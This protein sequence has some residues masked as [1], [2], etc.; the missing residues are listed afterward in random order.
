M[1]LDQ[2]IALQYQQRGFVVLDGLFDAE[3]VQLMNERT[4]TLFGQP[5]SARVLEKDGKTVRAVHGCHLHDDLFGAMVRDPRLIDPAQQ[6]LGGDVYVFQFKINAKAAFTGDVWEWHQ[7]Y[8][9]WREE[10]GVER[11]D[12]VNV[13]IFLD[14]VHE[15]NGPLTFIPGSH[16][17]GV[18]AVPAREG[19]PDSYEEAPDWI[20]NLTADIKYRMRRQ[21]IERLVSAHGIEAPKGKA[22]SVL[23]FH[24]NVVHASVGNLSP[25]DRSLLVTTY[26]LTT[27]AAPPQE[28]PRPEFLV[29]RDSTPLRALES[30]FADRWLQPA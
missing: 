30:S 19:K 23:L 25:F 7:D 2:D 26:N 27:N 6:L 21:E 5:S 29:S 24:P 20:S 12:L 22:G 16:R 14:E 9:F 3:E 13:A 8:I 10:D 18:L 28:N 15:F 11:C 1:R 4:Q 17:E